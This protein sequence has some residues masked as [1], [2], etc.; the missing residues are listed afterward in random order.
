MDFLPPSQIRAGSASANNTD[1]VLIED[2]TPFRCAGIQLTGTFVATVAFQITL[3]GST[4]ISA[5]AQNVNGAASAPTSSA[6]APG[7]FMV[8][9]CARGFRVRTTA[10]TSGTVTANVALSQLPASPMG[11]GGSVAVA[12][13]PAI[14]AGTNTIGGVRLV[15]DAGQGAASHFLRLS[16]ADTNLATIKASAGNL[17]AL[18]VSNAHATNAAFVKLYNKASNPV[19]AS[20]T[21]VRIH[22]IPP[23]ATVD[24]SCGPFGTRFATGIALAITGAVGFT[25]TTAVGAN[26]IIVNASYT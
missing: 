25:D 21:P 24:L 17:S 14:A 6:T 23:G 22:R 10:Y 12:S 5:V 2:L 13:A 9:V 11:M 19:L 7:L 18:S 3:D 1:L 4:W 16:T 20:D 15:A 26:D 8:S